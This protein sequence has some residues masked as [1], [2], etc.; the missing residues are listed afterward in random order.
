VS[1]LDSLIT[2]YKKEHCSKYAATSI[3][4]ISGALD[5]LKSSLSEEEIED[6]IERR[7]EYCGFKL[8]ENLLKFMGELKTPKFIQLL[9]NDWEDAH[10]NMLAEKNRAEKYI[11]PMLQVKSKRLELLE[12]LLDF[13]TVYSYMKSEY[14]K[15]DRNLRLCSYMI[16]TIP[17][18][19]DIMISR[20]TTTEIEVIITQRYAFSKY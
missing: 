4:G 20:M 10:R 16:C 12:S 13:E 9:L 1:A 18:A 17:G 3:C 19:F 2:L 15:S 11:K 14:P 5:S 8:D 6:I 7:Y